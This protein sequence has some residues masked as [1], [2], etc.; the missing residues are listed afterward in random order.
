MYCSDMSDP[1][2]AASTKASVATCMYTRGVIHDMHDYIVILGRP[3][4]GF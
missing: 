1:P 2:M 4:L 3:K